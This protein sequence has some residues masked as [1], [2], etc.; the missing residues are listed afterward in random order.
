MVEKIIEIDTGAFLAINSWHT[1]S[2]DQWMLL[3]SDR[4]VWVPLY[5]LIVVVLARRYGWR[6]AIGIALLAGVVIALADQTC[7]T[8]IRPWVGRLRPSN[9][10]NPLSALTHVVEG[11]RGGANGFPSCHAANC[12][13]LAVYLS[14]VCRRVLWSLMAWVAVNCYSR[15]YLGVHY[16][17]DIATGLLIGAVIGAAVYGVALWMRNYG[18][19]H[20]HPFPAHK[21]WPM[22]ARAVDG[23]LGAEVGMTVTMLMAVSLIEYHM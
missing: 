20:Y 23:W 14:M 13:A 5:A 19:S 21:S 2:L 18:R 8:L 3:L 1:G 7:A 17:G 11:H 12:M 4:W 15:I 16:P 6:A 10:D 22:S 9:L